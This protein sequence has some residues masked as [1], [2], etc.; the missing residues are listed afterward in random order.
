LLH[1]L[2]PHWKDASSESYTIRLIVIRQ[3]RNDLSNNEAGNR[4]LMVVANRKEEV[5][6]E[7]NYIVKRRTVIKME[8]AGSTARNA[9]SGHGGGS[10]EICF[11]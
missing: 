11:R 4:D 10:H 5:A 9:G 7:G 3:G 2:F 1:V 6:E 8:T